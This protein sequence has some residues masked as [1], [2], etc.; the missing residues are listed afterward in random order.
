MKEKKWHISRF[1][2][3][4]EKVNKTVLTCAAHEVIHS[5]QR[6]SRNSC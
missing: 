5:S 2:L 3:R 1:Q 6:W 4:K